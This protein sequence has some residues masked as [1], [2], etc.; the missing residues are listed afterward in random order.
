MF[1]KE[2]ASKKHTESVYTVE[3]YTAGHHAFEECSYRTNL[4]ANR[5]QHMFNTHTPQT[6]VNTLKGPNLKTLQ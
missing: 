3:D 2:K 1:P 5:L 6:L 4:A